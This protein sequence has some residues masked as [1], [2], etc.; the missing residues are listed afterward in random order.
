MASKVLLHCWAVCH[1]VIDAIVILLADLLPHKGHFLAREGELR[2]GEPS[3]QLSPQESC[4][5]LTAGELFWAA[6]MLYLM[7]NT[8]TPSSFE[9]QI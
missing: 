5:G 7:R 4:D 3:R 2:S 1:G 8:Q 6:S 9:Q